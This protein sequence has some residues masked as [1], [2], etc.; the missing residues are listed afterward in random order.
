[1]QVKYIGPCTAGV[2][3]AATGQEVARGGVVTVDDALGL[4]LCDQ[5]TNW[6]PDGE[7][8][9]ALYVEFC[10]WVEAVKAAPTAEDKALAEAAERAAAPFV[11]PEQFA[12]PGLAALSAPPEPS[13]KQRTTTT[14]PAPADT[15]EG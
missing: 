15:K 6:A 7:A 12:H 3:I 1:M 4:S 9:I 8:S 10:R 11:E 13:R 5:P 14:D 2:E